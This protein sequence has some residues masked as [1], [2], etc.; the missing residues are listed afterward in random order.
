MTATAELLPVH[1]RRASAARRRRHRQQLPYRI[2]QIAPGAATI[3]VT[4]IWTDGHS[5]GVRHYLARA[6]D[7]HGRI[8]KFP[9]GGSQRIAGLPQGAHPAADWNR[10]QT[11]HAATNTLTTRRPTSN[12]E[13]RATIQRMA[14]Q[15]ASLEAQLA[16]ERERRFELVVGR[17]F[18]DSL[19]S[20]YVDREGLT[21]S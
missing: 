1:P 7:G 12:A 4:P 15:A 6:L 13:M 2:H 20:G 8:L 17:D 9:A 10:P 3:L 16:F 11:W 18:A 19:A 14:E 5:D 21:V